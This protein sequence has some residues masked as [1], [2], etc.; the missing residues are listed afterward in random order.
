MMVRWQWDQLRAT[1][2]TIASKYEERF[3]DEL[4]DKPRDRELLSA[5]AASVRDPVLEVGCGPGQ[6]GA[7]IRKQ[8]RCVMGLDLSSEMANLATHRLDGALVGDMRSLPLAQESLGGL[9]A[10]YSIIHVQR[11]ELRVVLSEFRRV[12][13]PGGRVLIAVHE[14]RGVVEHNRFLEVPVPSIATLYELDELVAASRA[15]GLDVLN[16]ERREPYPS[17]STV[18]LFVE[19]SA[20]ALPE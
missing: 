15:V 20:M 1:Y 3:L 11:P 7:F 6:I 16:A 5:F 4:E 12:V 14:G 13:R 10:F 19:A 18:R 8:G 17:E 9:V 2:D